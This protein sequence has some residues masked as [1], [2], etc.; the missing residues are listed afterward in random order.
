MV[1]SSVGKVLIESVELSPGWKRSH[2]DCDWRGPSLGFS[3]NSGQWTDMS[4]DEINIHS[5]A[6]ASIAESIV[7]QINIDIYFSFSRY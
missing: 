7:A 2:E 5:H 1:A 4:W 3:S 6:P